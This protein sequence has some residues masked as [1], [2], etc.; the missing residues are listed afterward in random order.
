MF[1]QLPKIK[2]EI[3]GLDISRA[4]FHI[5]TLKKRKNKI[6]PLKLLIPEIIGITFVHSTLRMKDIYG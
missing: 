4:A 5:S 2:K 1:V 3:Y 6:I